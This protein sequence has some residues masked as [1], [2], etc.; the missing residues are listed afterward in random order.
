MTFARFL[1]VVYPQKFLWQ[2][3]RH[4]EMS[5]IC[6]GKIVGIFR[7]FPG[8]VQDISWTFPG[9]YRQMSSF[10]WGGKIIECSWKFT[11]GHFL[12][13]SRK[14][15]VMSWNISWTCSAKNQESVG[16][17]PEMPWK[18]FRTFLVLYRIFRGHFPE[19]SRNVPADFFRPILV[20]R[21]KT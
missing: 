21:G 7:T 18:C 20:S 3:Y 2:L 19:N 16:I 6:C 9:H 1:F 5:W 17:V 8:Y 14:F 11:W 12:E 4:S 15:P 13:I 10:C